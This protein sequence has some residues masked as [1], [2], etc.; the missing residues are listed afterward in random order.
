MADNKGNWPVVGHSK[1]RKKVSK[2]IF[3]VPTDAHYYKLMGMLKQY[4]NYNTSL[5]NKHVLEQK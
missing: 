1:R 4:K 5:L 2:T 3:I